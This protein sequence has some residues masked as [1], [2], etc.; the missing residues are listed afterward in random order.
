[1]KILF[2]ILEHTSQ[3]EIINQMIRMKCF[4]GKTVFR[5]NK[6]RPTELKTHL[7]AGHNKAQRCDNL[8]RSIQRLIQMPLLI[9]DA[10][11]IVERVH[12][13]RIM[14]ILQHGFTD[15]DRYHGKC[16]HAVVSR[17][18]KNEVNQNWKKC[19]IN[20]GYWRYIGQHCVSH[21]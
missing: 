8:H 16:A 18:T 9:F 15:H 7:N 5:L 20:A 11:W 10:G 13:H 14:C 1:M 17:R 21:S 4:E 3:A 19:R 12:G 6:P 2:L